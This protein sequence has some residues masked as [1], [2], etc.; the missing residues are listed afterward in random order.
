VYLQILRVVTRD[1]KEDAA[2][3]ATLVALTRGMQE[4]GSESQAGRDSLR[5]AYAMAGALKNGFVRSVHLDISQQR[6]V[7]ALTETGE[8][9]LQKRRQ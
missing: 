2:V 7:V 3:G 9:R 8:M 1:L 6:E 5:V 4:A